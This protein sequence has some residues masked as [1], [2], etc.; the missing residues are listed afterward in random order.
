ME[1]YLQNPQKAFAEDEALYEACVKAAAEEIIRRKTVKMVFIS[2]PSCVGKTPTKIRL[3]KYL[4]EAGV[5]TEDISLDD[6]YRSSEDCILKEDGTPD[7]ESP[8]SLDLETLHECF[9]ALSNGKSTW[10]PAFDF[11]KKRRSNTWRKMH[12][13]EQEICIVEGLH[14]LNPAV[15]GGYISADK[16]FKIYLDADSGMEESP[17]KLRRLVRDYFKRSASAEITLAMWDDVEYGSKE[18]VFPYEKDA[19]TVIHTYID[20]ETFVMR[21]K[22]VEILSEVDEGSL[23][24]EEAQRL[25][26]KLEGVP[27][28]PKDGISKDSLMREFIVW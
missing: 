14:A 17:R 13:D 8:E 28:L 3:V 4:Q 6:F 12:L 15:C 16:T 18:Y 9:S 19:D 22:A 21:D 11:I 26:K 7:F 1:R 27:S 20:Y 25:L 5:K 24:Y 10:L 2:G 23:Y